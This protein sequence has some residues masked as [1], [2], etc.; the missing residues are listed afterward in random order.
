M[1]STALARRVPAKRY[2]EQKQM[3]MRSGL[4]NFFDADA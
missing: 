3:A 2:D 4:Q 1:E